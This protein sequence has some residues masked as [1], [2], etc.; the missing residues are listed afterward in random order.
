VDAA[1]VRLGRDDAAALADDPG[2]HGAKPSPAPV[3]DS[4]PTR[5][6]AAQTRAS[7][8]DTLASGRR[9]GEPY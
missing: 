4:S 2:E 9:P 1:A 6:E 3:D 8:L 5:P 7:T